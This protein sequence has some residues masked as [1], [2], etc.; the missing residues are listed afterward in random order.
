MTKFVSFFFV[1]VFLLGCG[2]SEQLY[3]SGPRLEWLANDE[4][5]LSGYRIYR[6]LP[7]SLFSLWKDAGLVTEYPLVDRDGLLRFYVLTAYDTS[8]NESDYSN[9]VFWLA[10]SGDTLIQWPVDRALKFLLTYDKTRDTLGFPLPAPE[11][12]SLELEFGDST[13]WRR[14][15]FFSSGDTLTIGAGVFVPNQRWSFR[16]RIVDASSGK[17]SAWAYTAETIV[18]V[19]SE[20]A[21]GVPRAPT[22]RLIH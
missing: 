20:T 15:S 19:I 13:L 5:D 10:A 21:R 3:V 4:S 22:F 6:R 9:E 11:A 14:L 16:A 12:L 18:F 17:F 7:D 2:G 1:V 8:G